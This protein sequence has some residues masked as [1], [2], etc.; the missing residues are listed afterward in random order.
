M[1]ITVRYRLGGE[2]NIFV[3]DD[4]NFVRDMMHMIRAGYRGMKVVEI[5]DRSQNYYG[6]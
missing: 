1:K 3:T 4:E 2:Y 6:L 5:L